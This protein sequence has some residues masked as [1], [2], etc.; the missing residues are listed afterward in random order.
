VIIISDFKALPFFTNITDNAL[1]PLKTL[2]ERSG[3]NKVNTVPMDQD[4]ISLHKKYADLFVQE[5][6]VPHLL[7]SPFDL[8]MMVQFMPI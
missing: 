4:G 2:G 8:C 1:F 6:S 5:F 7:D 3:W